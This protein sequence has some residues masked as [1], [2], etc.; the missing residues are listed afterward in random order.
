MLALEVEF[1]T[2]RY[3]ATAHDDRDGWEWPP[4]PARLYSAMVAEWGSAEE[5]SDDERA[6]L[7]RLESMAPPS[8]AASAA[9]ERSVVTH[10]VPVNDANLTGEALWRRS[11]QVDQELETLR[12]PQLADKQRRAA[13]KRLAAARDVADLVV[14]TSRNG[15]STLPSDRGRQARTYPSVTPDSPVVTYVWPEADL[16]ASEKETLDG[17]LSRLTRLGHS[18]SLVNCRL[19]D[20]QVEPTL[21]PSARG[22][23]RLRGVCAGQLDALVGEFRMHQGSRPRSLP[24]TTVSYASADEVVEGGPVRSDLAGDWFVVH[25]EGPRTLPHRVVA[26]TTALRGA[27]LAHA[28]E[29]SETLHGHG[30]DGQ[31]TRRPHVSFLALPDVAHGH[32]TGRLMGLAAMLPIGCDHRERRALL[33]ALGRWMTNGGRLTVAGGHVLQAELVEA[34]HLRSLERATWAG[35]ALEYAS[36][37]PIALPWRARKAGERAN[38]WQLAEEWV[39]DSCE[40]IGLPRPEWVQVS[41]APL[42]QGTLPASRYPAFRQGATARRLVHARLR[43]PVPVEGP[44]V[45]GSGRFLGLGLMRPVG[46]GRDV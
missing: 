16:S 40:H 44:V 12:D 13:E 34:P 15:S 41:I 43:F 1:L 30:A 22:S 46:V 33:Q 24:A 4:H 14:A 3:V 37:V 39:A 2:G 45:L 9:V 5:P 35:P 27:V 8:I 18:S 19:T 6:V 21:V 31:P 26:V 20:A 32:G 11:K 29:H 42:L 23:V 10:Y 25:L 38:E 17:L 36:A 7:N 28:E